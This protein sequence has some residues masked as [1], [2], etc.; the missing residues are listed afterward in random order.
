MQKV[1]LVHFGRCGSTV[2]GYLLDQNQSIE[3]QGEIYTRANQNDIFFETLDQFINFTN[4]FI[5]YDHII[6]G[7]ELKYINFLQNIDGLNKN[8]SNFIDLLNFFLNQKFIVAL[9]LRNNVLRQLVSLLCATESNIWHIHKGSKFNLNK[10]IHLNTE[11]IEDFSIGHRGTLLK[12]LR[13]KNEY[14][15]ILKEFFKSQDLLVLEFEKHILPNPLI[16]YEILC[17]HLDVYDENRIPEI[18]L[19][20][21]ISHKP[22]REVI[23]N[24]EDIQ[25]LL[26]GSEFEWMLE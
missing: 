21:Q 14:N 23:D 4:V 25:R 26:R 11:D 18:T 16:G 5:R 9:L 15:L 2:L 22:L 8:I 17:R 24:N 3:W 1:L 13:I 6:Y 20:A 10:K 12:I 7:F 19:E